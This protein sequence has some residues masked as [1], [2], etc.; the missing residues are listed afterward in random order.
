MSAFEAGIMLEF[1]KSLH[2]T[3]T[4]RAQLIH[5]TIR[6]RTGTKV[7]WTNI[8][9]AAVALYGAVLSTFMLVSNTREKRR[10]V[11]VEIKNGFLP[12]GPELGPP[13][14]LIG[15]S[16]PGHRP[17][18]IQYPALRLPTGASMVF[19]EPQSDVRFPYELAEGKNCT[20]WA[21][22]SLIAQQLVEQGIT[23]TVGLVAECSDAVGITYKSKAWSFNASEWLKERDLDT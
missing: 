15:L 20:V 22:M 19:L 1:N 23:G 3:P 11:K 18:T 5:V 16:N 10:H 13:M 17:V 9:T 14:L 6:R 21:E 7:D 8:I 12:R 2:P 4:G